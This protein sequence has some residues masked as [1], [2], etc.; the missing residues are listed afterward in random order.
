MN[1]VKVWMED[2]YPGPEIQKTREGYTPEDESYNGPTNSTEN[3][4]NFPVIV[5]VFELDS[6]G[7]T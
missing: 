1:Q 4:G 2:T 3:V 6:T 5:V 7:C